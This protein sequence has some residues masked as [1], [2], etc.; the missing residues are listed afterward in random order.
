MVGEGGAHTSLSLKDIITT[1]VCVSSLPPFSFGMQRVDVSCGHAETSESNV[2]CC[3]PRTRCPH[4]CLLACDVGVVLA[5]PRN[6]VKGEPYYSKGS[7][8]WYNEMMMAEEEVRLKHSIQ[9]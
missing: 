9:L 8:F 7:A 3:T 4:C 2:M 1:F 6:T 5:S